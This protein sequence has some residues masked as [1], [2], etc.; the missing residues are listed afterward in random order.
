[1]ES[2]TPIVWRAIYVLLMIASAVSAQA[3]F[4]VSP[5]GSNSYP[6]TLAQ[7]FQTLSKALDTVQKINGSMTG[8]ITVYLR[9]GTYRITEPISIGSACSGTNGYYIRF[10]NYPGEVP[11]ISGGQVITGWTLYDTTKNIYQVTGPNFNF[12]QLYVNG[13]KAI[14]ARTPNASGC[15]NGPN[16]NR[17]IGADKTNKNIQVPSSVM[18]NW[19][20]FTDVEMHLMINWGDNTLRLASYSV[21]GTTAYLK[22]KTPEDD[23]LYQRPYPILASPVN[24]CYYFENAYEFLDAEGEWYLNRSTNTLYY[25]PRSG[26]TMAAATVIAP[27]V[28]TLL[29]LRGSSTTNQAHH[30]AFQGITFAHSTDLRPSNYG[31][32]DAQA[33]QYNISANASNQ[34]YVAR[35]AAAVYVACANHIRFERNVFTQLANTG[36]DF[37]Y[38]THDDMIQGNVFYD[39]GGNGISLAK[40]T[41]DT[42]TEFHVPYNPTDTNERC[43]H[44][45]IK[46]NYICNVTTEIQGACGIACGYPRYVD[47]E[48]NEICNVNYT[49][50]SVGFGWTTTANAMAGNRIWRNN[51]HQVCTFM[52]DGAAIYTLSNQS[53]G[54]VMQ[55]NFIHDWGTSSWADYADY[56]IYNDEGT[57][58]YDVSNNVMVNAPTGVHYNGPQGTNTVTNNSGTSQTTIDSAGIEA[59]YRDILPLIYRNAPIFYEAEACG[60]I[61]TGTAKTANATEAS[62]GLDVGYVG[63][64]ANNFL[65]FNGI[66]VSAAGTFTF[67]IYY[68]CGEVRTASI[69]I[70]GGTATTVSFPSTGSYTKVGSVTVS[71]MLAAGDNTIRFSNSSAYAPDFD[72]VT[73]AI[74]IN[75]RKEAGVKT[76]PA[77]ALKF[78]IVRGRCFFAV[79]AVSKASPLSV[80]LIN[81][82][83]KVVQQLFNTLSSGGSYSADIDK[84]NASGIYTVVIKYGSASKAVRV[85]ML[86]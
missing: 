77:G 65:Q 76:L 34:Q 62:G 22:I 11:E 84:K 3:I 41:Q 78:S 32:I 36:L 4:Y 59:A 71:I 61:L 42:A 85:L 58:G 80:K 1:M 50:I 17:I 63:N 7:P 2:A 19:G 25:K 18:A 66:S 47:I 26:E 37:N 70:N 40:F 9:G 68:L 38:G 79:P 86:R 56:S 55:Y 69:S 43:V 23:I 20:N 67:T 27:K 30:I 82:S 33:G 12:R 81:C 49:G 74:P 72:R 46:N 45:T 75:I 14:R 83:G 35:P 15:S 44:D 13:I 53:P 8:D 54:S 73:L 48:H 29:S 21:T 16:F 5:S 6:G 31:Y 39:I 57:G 10:L 52:A 64:G 24:Q 28:D 51:L 60:N